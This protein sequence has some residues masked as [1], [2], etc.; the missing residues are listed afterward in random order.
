M[1]PGKGVEGLKVYRGSQLCSPGSVS[2]L[3][4]GL[5]RVPREH[6]AG[7][8]R[9]PVLLLVMLL[10]P[11]LLLQAGGVGVVGVLPPSAPLNSPIQVTAVTR[12]HLVACKR[13]MAS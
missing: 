2:L 12:D 7:V 4:A 3:F 1:K 5:V 10:L 13:I 11:L 8:W 6:G 9:A